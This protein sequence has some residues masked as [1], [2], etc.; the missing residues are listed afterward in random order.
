M[1][2][3][4]FYFNWKGSLISDCFHIWQNVHTLDFN[5]KFLIRLLLYLIYILLRLLIWSEIYFYIFVGPWSICIKCVWVLLTPVYWFRV[6][7]GY[8][9]RL[10]VTEQSSRMYQLNAFIWSTWQYI[11]VHVHF[12]TWWTRNAKLHVFI[13]VHQF[14][15]MIKVAFITMTKVSAIY[16]DQLI[17]CICEKNAKK[18]SHFS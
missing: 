9:L 18:E 8:I 1:K 5:S 13:T 12:M 14:H 11:Q 6:T 10:R 3:Y 2:F 17:S 16:R 15:F 7:G 4:I